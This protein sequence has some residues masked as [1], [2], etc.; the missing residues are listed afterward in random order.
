MTILLGSP[1]PKSTAELPQG[2]EV[3]FTSYEAT[4]QTNEPAQQP[5]LASQEKPVPAGLAN[6]SDELSDTGKIAAITPQHHRPHFFERL[7]A[8]RDRLA[9]CLAL[10]ALGCAAA[11]APTTS[12]AG[13]LRA[14]TGVG[15][16]IEQPLDTSSKPAPYD[17]RLVA[18]GLADPEIFKVN[19]S[20][21]LLSGTYQGQPFPIYYSSDLKSFKLVS[22]YNPGSSGLDCNLWAPDFS[23]YNGKLEMLFSAKQTAQDKSCHDTA[24][25]QTIYYAT[26]PLNHIQFGKPMPI[27][28][29]RSLPHTRLTND[30]PES[31]CDNGMHS[32]PAVFYDETGNRW[33]F[34]VW[35]DGNKHAISGFQP[36]SGKRLLVVPP[37]N[38]EENSVV[39][40]PFVFSRNGI[41]YLLYSQ[42]SYKKHYEMRYLMAHDIADLTL[43]GHT[44]YTLSVP[45]E[46]TDGRILENMGHASVVEKDGEYYLF[47]HVGEFDHN[48]IYKGR[49]SYMQ[50]LAFNPDGTMDSI[51]TLTLTWPDNL[52][53]G[54]AYSVDF[55]LRN[56]TWLPNCFAPADLG[57]KSSV[58]F[59][60]VCPS[61]G[62]EMIQKGDITTARISYLG[63]AGVLASI[64]ASYDGHSNNLAFI[65]ASH[66]LEMA[67]ASAKGDLLLSGFDS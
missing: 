3:L 2:E 62:N 66:N 43:Q 40:A 23:R 30:C 56:G 1:A 10:A 61:A 51:N 13:S 38:G 8:G 63:K 32:D 9:G 27:V 57:D 49:S 7:R 31:G 67:A 35:M 11:L 55:Q 60:G 52:F 24:A 16:A 22:K 45:I 58:E 15:S 18:A 34:Y 33:I 65:T 28:T 54:A 50:R 48:G 5:W 19:G 39:E 21:Y 20:L 29:K 6:P 44:P 53:S 36:E 64:K 41:Y 12:H 17:R 59:T 46:S 37:D 47:Y 14:D 4:L 25:P 42:G 26:S